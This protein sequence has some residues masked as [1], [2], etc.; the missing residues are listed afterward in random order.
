MELCMR[1]CMAFVV[2]AGAASTVEATKLKRML[3][4]MVHRKGMQG[5][6]AKIVMLKKMLTKPIKISEEILNEPFE[7]A[8]ESSIKFDQKY[9]D[10]EF[11][12]IPGLISEDEDVTMEHE[13][14]KKNVYEEEKKEN[15]LGFSVLF[16]SE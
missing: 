15:S 4:V 16:D 13:K 9:P 8:E 1:L 6:E 12:E 7:E 2:L 10:L 5:Q 11:P 14:K 3:D